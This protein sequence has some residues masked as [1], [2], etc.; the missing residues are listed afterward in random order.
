MCGAEAVFESRFACAV[1]FRIK[2]FVLYITTNSLVW[3]PLVKKKTHPESPAPPTCR[4]TSVV[5]PMYRCDTLARWRNY[6]ETP[7]VKFLTWRSKQKIFFD[8]PQNN[9]SCWDKIKREKER[10]QHR[11]QDRPNIF[12]FSSSAIITK[13]EDSQATFAATDDKKSH[14]DS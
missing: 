4:G 7:R 9:R 14:R 13:S 10:N 12:A 3:F 5:H 2:N 11:C 6:R 1:A 8:P